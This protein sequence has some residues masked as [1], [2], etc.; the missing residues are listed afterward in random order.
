MNEQ[1][2]NGM[3][4]GDKVRYGALHDWIKEYKPKSMFCE[5]C[6]KVTEKL[7]CANI[8]GEYKRDI[9]DWRW[10]CRK[11]HMESDGRLDKLKKFNDGR[12]RKIIDEKIICG[13]CKKYKLLKE[14]YKCDTDPNGVR[15]NCK[16]CDKMISRKNYHKK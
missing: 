7:D 16:E 14:F 12:E 1:E 13:K 11:C 2:K 9:S 6:G 8:S 4:K 15:K 10:L 3:W 5:K